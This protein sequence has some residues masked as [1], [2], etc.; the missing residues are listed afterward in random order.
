MN[1]PLNPQIESFLPLLITIRTPTKSKHLLSPI[2]WWKFLRRMIL[3]LTLRIVPLQLPCNDSVK[4]LMLSKQHLNPTLDLSPN[5]HPNRLPII[6]WLLRWSSLVMQPK[7]RLLARIMI[8]PW[9]MTLPDRL[10]VETLC[11]LWSSITVATWSKRR[12]LLALTRVYWFQTSFQ[13]SK[14]L[15]TYSRY[16]ELRQ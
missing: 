14:W 12:H 1:L 15:I 9:Q 6:L 2:L 16:T 7:Q 10:L 3:Q 13:R 8:L 11:L 4:D 5:E